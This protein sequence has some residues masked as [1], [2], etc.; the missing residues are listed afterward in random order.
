MFSEISRNGISACGD[1]ERMTSYA[2]VIPVAVYL[3]ISQSLSAVLEM[4]GTSVIK[5]Q[6]W[7]LLTAAFL[8]VRLSHLV[9]NVLFLCILGWAAEQIIGHVNLLLLWITSG[10]AGSIAEL[11]SQEPRV[12]SL[13]ASGVVYGLAGTLLYVY[14]FRPEILPNKSRYRP[15]ALM[16]VFVIIGFLGEWYVFGRPT[17]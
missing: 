8:H 4:Q 9:G 1:S 7:R 11:Y 2:E 5:G 14:S 12:T 17:P 6:W 15:I 13:G 16:A 3:F 10:L